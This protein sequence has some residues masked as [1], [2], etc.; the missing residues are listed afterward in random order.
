[1]T[2]SALRSHFLFFGGLHTGLEAVAVGASF[3][4]VTTVCEPVEMRGCYLCIPKDLRLFREAE[5]DGMITLKR[6]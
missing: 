2:R 1:M 5:V 4:E 6:S 3:E